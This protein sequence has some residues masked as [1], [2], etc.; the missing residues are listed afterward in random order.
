MMTQTSSG[1]QWIRAAHAPRC[2][3]ECA[4]TAAIFTGPRTLTEA[5]A[6]ALTKKMGTRAVLEQRFTDMCASGLLVP[7][8]YDD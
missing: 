4:R 2:C 8:S 5:L 3:S 6:I 7:Y 1:A